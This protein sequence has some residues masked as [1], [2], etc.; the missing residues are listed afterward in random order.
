MPLEYCSTQCR[1]VLVAYPPLEFK[2]ISSNLGYTTHGS[3]NT[4]LPSIS[5]TSYDL[6]RQYLHHV[7]ER[8]AS[9]LHSQKTVNVLTF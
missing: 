1:P 6:I 9:L 7:V 4:A 8:Q 2:T 3:G 5:D